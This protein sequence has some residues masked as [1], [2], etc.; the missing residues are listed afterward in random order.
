MIHITALIIPQDP[1]WSIIEFQLNPL[2]QNINVFVSH[3]PKGEENASPPVI[4]KKKH[5]E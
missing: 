2:S 1:P 3:H 5:P 4:K